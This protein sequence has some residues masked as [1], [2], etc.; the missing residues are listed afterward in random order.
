MGS[1]EFVAEIKEQFLKTKK[2][3]RDLPALRSL[4]SRPSFD[5]I[6]KA[7][8][9]ALRSDEKVARQVKLHLCHRYSGR[10]LREIGSR[11]GMGLSGVTQ[12]S[13]R[14]GLKAE[15]NKKLGKLLKRI[16]K[17]IFL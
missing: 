15:K 7:V 8:D 2:P 14:I 13:H 16:E 17:N 1:A 10:K 11:Y 3:D 12:A 4:S 9:S 5:Q 6:E